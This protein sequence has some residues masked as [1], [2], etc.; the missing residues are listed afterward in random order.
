MV[1]RMARGMMRPLRHPEWLRVAAWIGLG[2]LVVSR[3]WMHTAGFDVVTTIALTDI[4]TYELPMLLAIIA[5]AAVVHRTGRGAEHR[6]WALLVAASSLVLPAEIYW[7]WY[8]VIVDPR[9]PE[10]GFGQVLQLVA[11]L[12][13]FG[14]IVTMTSISRE[15]FTTQLR[16]YLDLLSTAAVSYPVVY[17][18]W[19]LPAFAGVDAPGRSMPAVGALYP[20]FGGALVIA[21]LAVA[22][23]WQ[24]HAWTMWERLVPASLAICGLALSSFPLWYPPTITQHALAVSWFTLP[25]GIA[26][27]LLFVAAVY[28]LTCE[29]PARVEPW[30]LPAIGSEKLWRFYPV[31]LATGVLVMGWMSATADDHVVGGTLLV[32]AV[33][34]AFIISVRSWLAALERAQHHRTAM[35]EPL[36]GA[37]TADALLPALRRQ[38]ADAAHR[39]REVSVVAIGSSVSDSRVGGS[40]GAR[41]AALARLHDVMRRMAPAEA[42]IFRAQPLSFT[43]VLEGFSADEALVYAMGVW[44]EASSAGDF[45]EVG[46]DVTGGVATFPIHSMDAA[47]LVMRASKAQA[48]ARML[49]RSPVLVWHEGLDQDVDQDAVSAVRIRTVLATVRALAQAV[50]ARHAT[51]KDHSTN[52]ADLATALARLYEMPPERVEL[53]ELAALVHDV[54]KVALGDEVLTATPPLEGAQKAALEM[55]PIMSERIIAAARLDAV[56]PVVRHH[57]ERWDGKGYPDGLAGKDIPLESRILAVCNAFELITSGSPW[58]EPRSV[59]SALGE[60]ESLAGTQFDPDVVNRFA[61]LLAGMGAIAR[62]RTPDSQLTGEARHAS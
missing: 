5:G 12:L 30:P 32:A 2:L 41:D 47:D 46:F 56:L 45:T 9:G 24:H 44:Q 17:L 36:T 52:V 27:Y 4:L 53:L 34:T 26:F 33:V 8:A 40:Q 61:R 59:A 7:T 37:F 14:V 60:L 55:H 28:R 6:F 62:G 51:T 25:V 18:W 16:F 29:V 22:I 20:I 11:A 54:G 10:L 50:D 58:A 13:F 42:P 15:R 21:S 31:L 3:V 49:P 38:L 19:T 35:T 1:G 43:V 57:H 23:G 39:G 48:Q